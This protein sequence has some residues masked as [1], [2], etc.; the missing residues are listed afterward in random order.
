MIGT[1]IAVG[2][3]HI[4]SIEALD[5]LLFLAALAASYRP[6]D[7][8]HGL[9][10]VSAFTV[11]HSITLA[12]VALNVVR[13]PIPVVE[14]LIPCTIV[15]AAAENLFDRGPRPAGSLRP[16][17]AGLFG[18]VHGAGFATTLRDLFDGGVALPLLGFNLGIELGQALVLTTLIFA[19]ALVDRTFEALATREPLTATRWRMRLTSAAVACVALVLVARRLPW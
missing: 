19:L 18:L 14:F 17:L 7:W 6:R 15:I 9:M 3:R 13:F 11:G 2:F 12:L 16:I 5:H 10:V 4:V 1:F 8:R